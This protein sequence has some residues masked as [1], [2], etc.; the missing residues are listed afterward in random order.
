MSVLR[1]LLDQGLPRSTA[2]Y[3]QQ[4]GI[5]VR[6]V[7]EVELAEADDAEILRYAR[8]QDQI[9]VTLDADFH[10]L[11]ALARA[12]RPSVIRVRIEGLRGAELAG[13]LVKV[14]GV[15]KQDL[16]EGALVSV[17][18]TGLRLRRLPLLR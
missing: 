6:H 12:S 18:Q 1:L 17:N 16:R 3:L 9:V 2:Q 14:V 8:V 7:G 13:L 11:L 15:C 10:K 5:E 4:S